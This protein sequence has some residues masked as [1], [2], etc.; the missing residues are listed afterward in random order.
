VELKALLKPADVIKLVFDCVLLLLGE[1][2][3]RT[4]KAEV[5]VGIGRT[6]HEVEFVADSYTLAKV[7]WGRC[8]VS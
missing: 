6:K 7:C 2:V 3:V 5:A 4:A 8:R 1:P